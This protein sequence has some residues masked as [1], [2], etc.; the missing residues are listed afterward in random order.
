[1]FED[2]LY[3]FFFL[4]MLNLFDIILYEFDADFLIIHVIYL[5]ISYCYVTEKITSRQNNHRWKRCHIIFVCC[6]M[7]I[8]NSLSDYV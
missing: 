6:K 1:M 2:V 3:G 4:L 8:I 5:N 7:I